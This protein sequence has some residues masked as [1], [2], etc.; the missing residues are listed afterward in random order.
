MKRPRRRNLLAKKLLLGLVA[1]AC[2]LA[3]GA[4]PLSAA[5]S[6]TD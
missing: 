3:V 2:L 5:P 6:Y 1:G 4:I